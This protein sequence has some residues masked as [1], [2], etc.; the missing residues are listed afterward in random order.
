MIILLLILLILGTVL[1]GIVLDKKYSKELPDNSTVRTP[2]IPFKSYGR[3]NLK[4]VHY[5]TPLP[6]KQFGTWMRA[7]KKKSKCELK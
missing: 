1:L 2:A 7:N 3:D 4:E 6:I 5:Q